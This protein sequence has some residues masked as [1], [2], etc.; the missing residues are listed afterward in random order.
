MTIPT[1]D[2]ALETRLVVKP[3][4]PLSASYTP[5]DALAAMKTAL[6]NA[7]FTVYS[8]FASASLCAIPTNE[9]NPKPL[10]L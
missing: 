10:G 4:T 5:A 7:G 8:D 3:G 2:H 6:T 9:A 1:M